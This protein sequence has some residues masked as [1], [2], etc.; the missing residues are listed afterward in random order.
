MKFNKL[1]KF[2]F[3]FHLHRE[4][5]Q[6]WIERNRSDMTQGNNPF[7]MKKCQWTMNLR[8]HEYV[9]LTSHITILKYLRFRYT[10]I[11][12]KEPVSIFSYHSDAAKPCVEATTSIKTEFYFLWLKR[13]LF[14]LIKFFFPQVQQLTFNMSNSP[15]Y[16]DLLQTHNTRPW[17]KSFTVENEMGLQQKEYQTNTVG[18]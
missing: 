7:F 3:F 9:C 6:S 8:H 10:K 5:S 12:A 18:V 4:E 16:G 1:I 14:S 15:Q 13:N 11:K 2:Q 17:G